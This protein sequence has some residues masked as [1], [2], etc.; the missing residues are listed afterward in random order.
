M[1]QKYISYFY[2]FIKGFSKF[3]LNI[4]FLIFIP[5]LVNLKRYG[6]QLINIHKEKY[7]VCLYIVFFSHSTTD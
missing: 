5:R 1:I 2:S 4:F 3:L 7:F 6:N